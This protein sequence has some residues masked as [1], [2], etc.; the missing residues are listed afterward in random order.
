MQYTLR[1]IPK[2]LDR[3][4]RRAARRTGKSLNQVAI[5][6]LLAVFGLGEVKSVRRRELSDL[7]GTWQPDPEAEKAL[8][9]QRTIDPD[10]WR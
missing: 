10:L 1:K 5:E 7:T 8:A 3:A 2:E 4:I 6:G 9:D